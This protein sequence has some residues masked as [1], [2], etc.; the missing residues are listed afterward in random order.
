MVKVIFRPS[1]LASLL[2]TDVKVE[3]TR[4]IKTVVASWR[5]RFVKNV[6]SIGCWLDRHKREEM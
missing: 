1:A 6:T 4:C 3:K 2:F 5:G